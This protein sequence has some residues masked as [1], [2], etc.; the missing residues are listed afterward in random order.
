MDCGFWAAVVGSADYPFIISLERS[1]T[2]WHYGCKW[3]C[4]MTGT[5]DEPQYAAAGWAM[6]E[7]NPE[8][9]IEIGST[10]GWYYDIETFATTL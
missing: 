5:A 2:V 3:K 8:F 9:T 1:V 10:K 4:L 6:L 7:G